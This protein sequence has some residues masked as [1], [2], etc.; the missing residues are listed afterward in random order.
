MPKK[1]IIAATLGAAVIVGAAFTFAANSSWLTGTVDQKLDTLA[2]I[3]PG[4]GTV[5]IEYSTRMG[6]IYYA[7]KAGNW[8]MA[9]YQLKEAVEIQEV[10][11]TTRPARAPLLKAFEDSNLK[12]LALDIVNQD[13]GAFQKDFTTTV[14]ACNVCHTGSGFRY[15]VYQLPSQPLVPAKLDTGDTFTK[16]ELQALLAELLPSK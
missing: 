4:L 8:G 10:G 2:S 13:I 3:Q 7:A 15:I 11:E 1:W 6:N 16:E 5:M 14:N 9:A 12:P